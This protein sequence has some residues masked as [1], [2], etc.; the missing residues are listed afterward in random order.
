M[1]QYQMTCQYFHRFNCGLFFV[2]EH[3]FTSECYF[4][5]T[6]QLCQTEVVAAVVLRVSYLLTASIFGP[7]QRKSIVN[8]L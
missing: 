6:L 3:I 1:G 8:W 7:V 2:T 4:V 5:C